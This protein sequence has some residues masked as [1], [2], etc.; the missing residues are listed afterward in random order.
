MARGIAETDRGSQS[1]PPPPPPQPVVIAVMATMAVRARNVR[2]IGSLTDDNYLGR[3]DELSRRQLLQAGH[4]TPD[5]EGSEPLSVT[6]A[7][8]CVTQSFRLSPIGNIA[9]NFGNLRPFFA[10]RRYRS[11]ALRLYS[12]LRR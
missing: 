11:A 10:A 6:T 4:Y 2:F 12:L 9:L 1:S 8:P 5:V 3:F 7:R